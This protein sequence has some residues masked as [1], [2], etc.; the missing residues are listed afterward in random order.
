MCDMATLDEAEWRSMTQILTVNSIRT[1]Q[2]LSGTPPEQVYSTDGIYDL[3]KLG[4]NFH[5]MMKYLE[6]A[7]LELK[8]IAFV[9]FDFTNP[10]GDDHCA[11]HDLPVGQGLTLP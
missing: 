1:E 8:C 9:D 4:E 11:I 5:P 3:L 10:E 7:E 6:E 2:D